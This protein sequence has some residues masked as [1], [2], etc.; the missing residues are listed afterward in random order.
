MYKIGL[1]ICVLLLNIVISVN[2][3]TD[4]ANSVLSGT[5]RNAKDKKIQG[6]T[7][8]LF[9]KSSQEIFRGKQMLMV[10]I[11]LKLQKENIN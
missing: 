5:V 11:Q 7:V 2:A 9:N 8:A 10:N 3:Q 4:S 6:V 1:I